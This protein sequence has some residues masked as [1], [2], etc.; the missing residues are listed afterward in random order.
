MTAPFPTCEFT[1]VELS[2]R[3]SSFIAVFTLDKNKRQ[4]SIGNSLILI[5]SDPR[6]LRLSVAK[7]SYSVGFGVRN[8]NRGEGQ[9]Q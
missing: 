2:S 7:Y 4:E 9:E 1:R 8:T 3:N 5:D 6:Y